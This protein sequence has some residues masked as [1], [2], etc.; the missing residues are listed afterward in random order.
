MSPY[1]REIYAR[2]LSRG[3]HEPY[4]GAQPEPIA[5]R[6]PRLRWP[7]R[8][9]QSAPAAPPIPSAHLVN[10]GLGVPSRCMFG[11]ESAQFVVYCKEAQAFVCGDHLG[12]FV[13]DWTV[14]R[15]LSVVRL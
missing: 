14:E 15:E 5:F 4:T 11:E 6:R 2:L 10:A 3:R 1:L 7:R 13:S 12:P 8:R 9:P